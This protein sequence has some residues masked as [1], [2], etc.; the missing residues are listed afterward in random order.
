MLWA[1]NLI[2]IYWIYKL[3]WLHMSEANTSA[4][5]VIRIFNHHLSFQPILFIIMPGDDLILVLWGELAEVAAPT[6]HPHD[7]VLMPFWVL[8]GVQ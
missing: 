4:Q 8:F 1:L 2:L 7:Q 6:P 3:V 5:L